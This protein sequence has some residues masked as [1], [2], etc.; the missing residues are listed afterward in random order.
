MGLYLRLMVEC[1]LFVLW[2]EVVVRFVRMLIVLYVVGGRLGRESLGM[3]VLGV[4]EGEGEGKGKGKRLL[5]MSLRFMVNL[6][7]MVIV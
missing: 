2:S 1:L 3:M 7:R 6:M 4:E 5:I